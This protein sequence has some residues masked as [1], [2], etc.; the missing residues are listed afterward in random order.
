MAKTPKRSL[1]PKPTQLGGVAE[2]RFG[3][4]SALCD[5]GDNERATGAL[6]LC[7]FVV[8]ILLKAQLLRA[9]EWA[10][11]RR[12]HEVS[13][14]ERGIWNL[15]WR[16]HDLPQMLRQLPQL[17]AAVQKA[18]ERRGKPLDV[19]LKQVCASWGI[20]L[21]YS[22]VTTTVAEARDML[23]RVR[24]LKEVLKHE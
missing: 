11:T 4:A 16:S 13:D 22:P 6:Y 12:S 18:G 1:M 5:T 14:A 2:R 3:D 10:A 20:E 17:Q 8:E 23:E 15:V 7:G 19:Y 24:A 21:R 9:H